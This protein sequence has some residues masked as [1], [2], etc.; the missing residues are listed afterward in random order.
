MS[1]PVRHFFKRYHTLLSINQKQWD[2]CIWRANCLLSL[3]PPTFSCVPVVMSQFRA[4]AGVLRGGRVG[5][6]RWLRGCGGGPAR[7][8]V[9]PSRGCSSG[10]APVP[11]AVASSSSYVEEMYFAW[12][13]D[14][15]S[16][17]KV[18]CEIY[19]LVN[20]NRKKSLFVFC[21]WM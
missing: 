12:L 9:D 1:N 7:R 15:K 14:H 2:V 3:S 19:T 5:G 8:Y 21:S 17:H 20:N 13:E 4:L 6:S 10:A 11:S 18:T 16:V